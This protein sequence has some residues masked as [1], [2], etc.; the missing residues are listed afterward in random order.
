MRVLVVEDEEAI[1]GAIERGLIKQGYEVDVARDGAEALE[2]AATTNYDVICLDLNL[3]RVDGIEVCRRLRE[4]RFPGGIIM[5]TARSSIRERIEGLDQG[6]DDYLVKPFAFSE[7]AARIRAITR[8]DGA[9]REPIIETRGLELDP[10]TNRCRRDGK[11]IHLTPKEF[12]LLYYLAR[13]EGRAV[14]QEELLEKIWDEHANPF[15]QTVKVHMNNLRRKLN[16]GFEEQ[17]IETIRGK[18]YVL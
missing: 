4:E 12:A 5:L 13:N 8:R 16:E 3:P 14:P 7:L 11:E 1:A 6:A 10:N 18:G 15:T 17:L 9:M 2:M